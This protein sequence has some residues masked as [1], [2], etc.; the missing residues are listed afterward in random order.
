MV[1]SLGQYC[2]QTSSRCR[3]S[4]DLKFAYRL[5]FAKDKMNRSL[6]R[7]CTSPCASVR[8]L[9]CT[10]IVIVYNFFNESTDS[11]INTTSPPPSIV[12]MVRASKF[13]V[14]A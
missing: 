8:N 6:K 10:S 12:S 14:I 9:E 5:L 13:G 7:Y 1:Y 2:S 11:N 3:K 4:Q